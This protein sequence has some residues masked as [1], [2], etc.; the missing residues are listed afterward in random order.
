MS[1]SLIVSSYKP[2][3]LIGGAPVSDSALVAAQDVAS[4]FVGVDGGADILLAAGIAP[5]AVIGDLDSLSGQAR[6]AFGA[7][8]HHVAEQETT[9]FEKALRRVKASSV[10]ALG[11]TGGR[12]D[13]LLSVLNTLARVRAPGVV[14]LDSYDVS[15]V[16]DA[17]TTVLPL[18]P[19]T[20]ISVMP[21]ATAQV[22]LQGVVWPFENRQ[23]QPGG[24]ASPSNRV[25]ADVVTLQTDGPVLVTLPPVCLRV[26]LQ[27]VARA[28]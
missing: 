10:I 17:G 23:M 20:R 26:A 28:G 1:S 12:V 25:A 3:C 7:V 4:A 5:V 8:L 27:A 18:A 16:V 9:D 15:F 22:S 21:I 6:A 11:F 13:H 14:L 19:D 24:F 2:V